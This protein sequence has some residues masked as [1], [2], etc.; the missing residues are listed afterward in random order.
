MTI[1]RVSKD[2]GFFRALWWL[3]RLLSV[4]GGLLFLMITPA[5][6]PNHADVRLLIASDIASMAALCGFVY[7]QIYIRKLFHIWATDDFRGYFSPGVT[8]LLLL[9]NT[10]LII[11]A[12]TTCLA[13]LTFDFAI[14]YNLYNPFEREFL[15]SQ[16]AIFYADQA[17]KGLLVDVASVF[18]LNLQTVLRVDARQHW[19]FGL[20]L[21]AFRLTMTTLTAVLTLSLILDALNKFR[22]KQG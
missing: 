5:L 10:A 11:F 19:C 18:N 14:R 6:I 17:M 22:R 9:I 20:L 2:A 1:H 21:V 4:L 12:L 7:F 15:L 13:V 16:I 3:R 8:W